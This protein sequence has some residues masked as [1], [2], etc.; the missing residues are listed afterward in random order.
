MELKLAE[1][2]VFFIFFFFFLAKFVYKIMY[3]FMINFLSGELRSLTYRG[4]NK[5][6]ILCLVLYLVIIEI[7]L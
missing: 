3:V 1:D 4:T 7:G 6:V 2:P 5:P